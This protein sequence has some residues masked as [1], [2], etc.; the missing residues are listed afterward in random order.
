MKKALSVILVLAM[1][2]AMA[3]SAFAVEFVES[4]EAKPAPEVITEEYEGKEVGALVVNGE[5]KEVEDGVPL[6]DENA[7]DTILE[8]S[9]IS[10]AEKDRA[11]LPEISEKLTSA[12]KQIKL[13][14]NLGKL[15]EGLDKEILNVIDEYYGD[16]ENKIGLDDLVVTDLFD[17]ELIRDKARIEPIGDGQKV[18]IT[19]NPSFTKNS[20]FLLLNNTD[21][22]N[23]EVVKDVEWTEEGY[24]RFIADNLGVFA[25]AVENRADLPVKP[26]GPESPQ[27]SNESEAG[28]VYLYAG[29]AVLCLGGAVFFFVK[30]KKRKVE[31]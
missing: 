30:S 2:A 15:D 12:E 10:A 8:L 26:D 16:S 4:I 9:V 5:T 18:R 31:E 11:V 22:T 21:G 7:S 13:A 17:A 25:F 19:L 28:N 1:V 14:A 23:W 24:I 6:Y 3:V 20:F 27:T 29:I